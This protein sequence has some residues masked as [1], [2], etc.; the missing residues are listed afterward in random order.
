MGRVLDRDKTVSAL[1]ALYK[2]NFAPDVGPFRRNNR[3]GRPYAIAGDGGLIMATNPK[4]LPHAFGNVQDWQFGY[5]N[6]CMS[7]FEHQ[8]ASHMIAEG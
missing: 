4:Q 3:P 1:K 6:E 2:Y 8:A 7:G 5:F